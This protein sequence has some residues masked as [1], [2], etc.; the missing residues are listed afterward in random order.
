MEEKKLLFFSPVEYIENN[1]YTDA[2]RVS[3]AQP[4]KIELN[5]MKWICKV[6]NGEQNTDR[7]DALCIVVVASAVATATSNG[8]FI[9]FS[10]Y[11]SADR[12]FNVWNQQKKQSLTHNEKMISDNI[13]ANLS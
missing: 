12:P 2:R 11:S 9:Y 13:R 6:E 3:S 7:E 5:G 1:A 10:T 8:I 4:N